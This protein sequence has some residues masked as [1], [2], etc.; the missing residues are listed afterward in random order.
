MTFQPNFGCPGLGLTALLKSPREAGVSNLSC[1]VFSNV[2]GWEIPKLAGGAMGKLRGYDE[3]YNMI[4][5]PS[6]NLT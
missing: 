3:G 5:L 6:G 2:A 4:Q 1:A